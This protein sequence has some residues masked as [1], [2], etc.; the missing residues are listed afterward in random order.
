MRALR[1]LPVLA[2]CALAGCGEQV[3][4]PAPEATGLFGEWDLLRACGGIGGGCFEGDVRLVIQEPDSLFLTGP[5]I[6]DMRSRFRVGVDQETIYGIHDV[7]ELWRDD[8]ADWDP[9]MVLIH[10][11]TDSLR[12][13]DNMYDGYTMELIR[14][15]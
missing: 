3:A 8:L 1:F 7:V 9:W 10:L 5:A 12:L 15:D 6:P 4:S 2:G 13:G 11:S 14:S